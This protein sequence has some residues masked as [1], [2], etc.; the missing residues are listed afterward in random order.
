MSYS[1]YITR[2]QRWVDSKASPINEQEWREAVKLD[3][4]LFENETD[5]CD[6]KTETGVIKRIHPVECYDMRDGNCLWWNNGK[7][8]C[9]NASDAWIAKMVGLAKVLKARVL[10][11]EDEQYK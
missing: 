5:F 6:Y 4:S 10:G 2:A 9:K 7:I 1:V 3:A 8:E 11:E